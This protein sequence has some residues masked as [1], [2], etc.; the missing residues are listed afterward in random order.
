M[1][2]QPRSLRI[3]G[4]R[5]QTLPASPRRGYAAVRRP[6]VRTVTSADIPAASS[7][8]RQG[9]LLKIFGDS[10]L[11]GCESNSLVNKAARSAVRAGCGVQWV[12]RVDGAPTFTVFVR[13]QLRFV[14][15]QR[16][17]TISAGDQRPSLLITSTTV[18]N[19]FPN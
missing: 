19:R 6:Y 4:E 1:S 13:A 14:Y 15:R 17:L 18:N 2:S 16:H 12:L 5:V 10:P 3:C 7:S 8:R 9:R 11:M